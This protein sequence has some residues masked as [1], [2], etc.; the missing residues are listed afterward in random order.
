MTHETS[1][2]YPYAVAA[3]SQ[4][5]IT[6]MQKSEMATHPGDDRAR[7]CSTCNNILIVAPSQLKETLAVPAISS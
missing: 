5:R 2:R 3:R 1:L 7:C 6:L 4:F